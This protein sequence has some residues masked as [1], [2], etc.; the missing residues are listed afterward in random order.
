[1][2]QFELQD[3]PDLCAIASAAN[4]AFP[5]TLPLGWTL[6]TQITSTS[7]L[8][9]I[10]AFLCSGRL[11]SN[12]GVQV[13]VL[14]IG[15]NR[16]LL[17]PW[18]STSLQWFYPL[19]ASILGTGTTLNADVQKNDALR[20]LL[21]AASRLTPVAIPPALDT[22]A[23]AIAELSI[24]R[25]QELYDALEQFGIGSV[26]DAAL[27]A[28]RMRAHRAF[29][30]VMREWRS[31]RAALDG[32]S[33]DFAQIAAGYNRL[34]ANVTLLLPT[35]ALDASGTTGPNVDYGY[36]TAYQQIQPA[37][38]SNITVASGQPLYIV[39]HNVG[40]PPA[41][42]AAIDFHPGRTS[43]VSPVASL[44]A[45]YFGGI[46]VGDASFASTS[47]SLVPYAYAVQYN[48]DFV[49]SEPLAEYGYVMTG[50]PEAVTG[51]HG[52][53]PYDSPWWQESGQLYCEL[54][55]DEASFQNTPTPAV[56]MSHGDLHLF[57]RGPRD[58]VRHQC[59]TRYLHE[60]RTW[61]PWETL[62][63]IA[64]G[65]APAAAALPNGSVALVAALPLGGVGVRLFDRYWHSWIVA[66]YTV[67]NVSAAASP[68]GELHIAGA[69]PD[70][71]ILHWLLRADRTW[72]R[73]VAIANPYAPDAA[74]VDLRFSGATPVAVLRPAAEDDAR[75]L[76]TTAFERGAWT[77]PAP[78]SESSGAQATE[79][80]IWMGAAARGFAR[81]LAI[82]ADRRVAAAE[83]MSD[84][85][86]ILLAAPVTVAVDDRS[87]GAAVIAFGVTADLR[88]VEN[89][90][91]P[92][93]WRGWMPL[94][95]GRFEDPVNGLVR[96]H[97]QRRLDEIARRAGLA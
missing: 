48:D 51:S 55:E 34:L 61:S 63:T 66:P 96:D 33:R 24:A 17:I 84:G 88:L 58:E 64:E 18:Y 62:G 4:A 26:S 77:P 13:Y 11:P 89:R 52:T 3:A 47:A 73:P 10:Q 22:T 12:P 87:G 44:E 39:G 45:Y 57:V 90:R 42:I 1:M 83:T 15:F 23:R 93:G 25:G 68:E 95:D 29:G 49:P 37:L 9:G 43:P 59:C 32:G 86:T 80:A 85:D 71:G 28:P 36:L 56:V 54:L 50:T 16:D 74:R 82:A 40:A 41:Q 94:P 14:S 46:A 67:T 53:D 70:G 21:A 31:L 8:S 75:P 79:G 6:G 60:S 5:P 72:T 38:W 20:P 92:N 35:L 65:T 97:S 91:D 7:Y 19:P 81:S 2:P 30:P 76:H 78:L 27:D 69:T